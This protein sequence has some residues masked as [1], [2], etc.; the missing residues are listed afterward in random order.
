MPKIRLASYH[1]SFSTYSIFVGIMALFISLLIWQLFFHLLQTHM[2][3]F[4]FGFGFSPFIKSCLIP[5]GAI[6]WSIYILNAVSSHSWEVTFQFSLT[7]RSGFTL[8][9]VMLLMAGNS[10]VYF[11]LMLY[12]DNLHPGALDLGQ[13]W[14]YFFKVCIIL[15]LFVMQACK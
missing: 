13:P 1:L 14:N 9:D 6:H 3:T 4:D 5:S 12:V 8:L 10:F 2:S 7:Q 11:F 15:S